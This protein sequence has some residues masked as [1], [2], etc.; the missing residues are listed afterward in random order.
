M[1]IGEHLEEMRSHLIRALLW[2]AVIMTICLQ[3]QEQI[4]ELATWPHR[5]TMLAIVE[6]NQYDKIRGLLSDDE[7]EA[8][9]TVIKRKKSLTI[10]HE[11]LLRN[12]ELLKRKF[13]DL[14]DGDLQELS[15]RQQAIIDEIV[16]LNEKQQELLSKSDLDL[17]EFAA[18]QKEVTKKSKEFEKVQEETQQAE[19]LIDRRAKRAN[20][21]VR[22]QQLSY[23]EAFMSYLKVSF[24][25]ALFIA[26]PFMGREAW[27]FVAKGLYPEEKRW[28]TVISP[29]SF[30][31]FICGALFGY[32]ILIPLGLHYLA[33]YGG[34]DIIEGSITLSEYLSIFITLTLV[35][36]LFFQLPL[37]MSFTTL[38]HI[39]TDLTFREKRRWFYFIAV[40]V[41]AFLTPPDPVTQVLMWIP[42]LILYELGIWL[43]FVIVKGRAQDTD[44]PPEPGATPPSD[45]DQGPD[46]GD[47]SGPES[48]SDASGPAAL[49]TEADSDSGEKEPE[50]EE[51]D[52]ESS[53]AESSDPE[54]SDPESS[55]SESSGDKAEEEKTEGE[56]ASEASDK[57]AEAEENPKA[58]PESMEEAQ[59]KGEV[60]EDKAESEASSEKESAPS[61]NSKDSSAEAKGEDGQENEDDEDSNWE[62]EVYPDEWYEELEEDEEYL[63]MDGYDT[64]EPVETEP[65]PVDENANIAPAAILEKAKSEGEAD[66]ED[67]PKGSSEAVTADTAEPANDDAP[68]SE[69]S[70]TKPE[71]SET[72]EARDNAQETDAPESPSASENNKAASDEVEKAESQEAPSEATEKDVQSA[73]NTGESPDAEDKTASK[74]D[75][76]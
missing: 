32:F 68:S 53:D 27:K 28:V 19:R 45:P 52:S 15:K 61:E 62:D 59:E 46:S 29:L 11:D 3:F 18:L 66:V 67:A 44:I 31:A 76:S 5:K 7:L 51:S 24:V 70:E 54:S 14:G 42:L 36:G 1:T 34:E 21:K 64:G 13:A 10:A 30:V 8:V 50:S 41:S 20:V 38:I 9:Q 56:S 22:L 48:P 60:A 6:A 73:E 17:T 43:S 49:T 26:G 4:L 71:E 75:P 2:L 69:S 72:E 25:L 55:D 57:Q 65:G 63:D 35:V 74:E 47:S 37:I 33:T 39:T 58:E 16:E 40:I 12:N 23:P